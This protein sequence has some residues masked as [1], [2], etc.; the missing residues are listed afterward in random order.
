MTGEDLCV[1]NLSCTYSLVLLGLILAILLLCA[2]VSYIHSSRW[3]TADTTSLDGKLQGINEQEGTGHFTAQSHIWSQR[4]RPPQSMTAD[5]QRIHSVKQSTCLQDLQGILV[6]SS[7]KTK[8][9]G[10]EGMSPNLLLG[11]HV[12]PQGQEIDREEEFLSRMKCPV[13]EAQHPVTRRMPDKNNDNWLEAQTSASVVVADLEIESILS[14]LEHQVPPPDPLDTRVF[15]WW[16]D[17]CARALWALNSLTESPTIFC[18]YR[19]RKLPIIKTMIS[20]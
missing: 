15:L 17:F 3:N 1:L 12:Q 8:K 14:R 2:M 13:V 11:E 9:S 7:S 4:R 16:L 19:L 20:V 6:D 5:Y 18:A 10:G